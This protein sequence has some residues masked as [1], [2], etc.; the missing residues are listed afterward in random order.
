LLENSRKVIAEATLLKEY[1][2]RIKGEI[3]VTEENQPTITQL[4]MSIDNFD[5]QIKNENGFQEKFVVK[6][7]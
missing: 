6:E 1:A 7:Q 4:T 5:K 3:E 2:E